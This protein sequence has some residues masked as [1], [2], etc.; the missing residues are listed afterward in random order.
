M[1]KLLSANFYAMI[2]SKRFWLGAILLVGAVALDVVALR[3]MLDYSEMVS[4]DKNFINCAPWQFI[5]LPC[6]CGLFI[7]TDYHDGT[8]R[9]KLT[10]GRSRAAV[11]ISNFITVYAVELFYMALSLLTVFI[12]GIGIPILDPWHVAQ[13]LG[14]L[15]LTFLALTAISVCLSTLITN[16]SALVICAVVGLSLMFGGQAINGLLESPKMIADYNGVTFTTNENGT[17]VMQYLDRNGNPIDPEDI[18]MVRNP[19]Y[20]D[21]PL[22]TVLRTVNDVQPGGQLWEIAWDGHREYNE[23]GSSPEIILTPRWLLVAYSLALTVVL[24]SA[25]IILFRRKDLK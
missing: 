8:I 19:S 15:M 20:I 5:L 6:L 11:Y 18:P 24:T 14:V 25:G 13:C 17:S 12:V 7:N 4:L 10:V 21:E 1:R 22:R 2:N 16:R 23:D 3:R 9:N